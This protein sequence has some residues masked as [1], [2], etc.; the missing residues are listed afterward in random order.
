MGQ[1]LTGQARGK[2]KGHG[3]GWGSRRGFGVTERVRGQASRSDRASLPPNPSRTGAVVDEGAALEDGARAILRREG[4]AERG[5]VVDEG[6]VADER[7]GV[8]RHE[9]GAL[10][11]G[12]AAAVADGEAC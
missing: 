12:G 9:H 6:A 4:R 5:H 7:R 10:A 2:G 3:E 11:V 1:P 8:A